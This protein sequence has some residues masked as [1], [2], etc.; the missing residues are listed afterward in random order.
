VGVYR[1]LGGGWEIR[2]GRDFVPAATQKTM[3]ERTNWGRILTPPSLPPSEPD[4]I[5]PRL[6]APDW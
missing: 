6:R 1:A 4:Q 2:E 3:E 5:K